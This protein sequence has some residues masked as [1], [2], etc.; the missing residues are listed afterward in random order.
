MCVRGVGGIECHAMRRCVCTCDASSMRGHA[1]ARAY[2]CTRLRA[3]DAIFIARLQWRSSCRLERALRPPAHSGK[4]IERVRDCVLC[5]DGCVKLCVVYGKPSGGL[6]R[7]AN[8]FHARVGRGEAWCGECVHRRQER[9]RRECVRCVEKYIERD[10][11]QAL[12][13]VE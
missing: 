7:I 11:L 4:A 6:S 5:M 3:C 1:R 8:G 9:V 2:N 13:R 12:E 10:I